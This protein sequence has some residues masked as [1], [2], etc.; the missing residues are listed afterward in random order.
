M[1]AHAS[2]RSR[3]DVVQQ[4]NR[5]LKKRLEILERD[6]RELKLSVHELS[7][8]LSAT[9]ARTGQP[10]QPINFSSHQLVVAHDARNILPDTSNGA[11]CAHRGPDGSEGSTPPLL[12][13]RQFAPKVDLVGHAGAVYAV[14]FS[15]NGRLLASGS[16][17]RSVRCWLIDA[18]SKDEHNETLILQVLRR[19]TTPFGGCR[20]PAASCVHFTQEHTHSVSTLSWAADSCSLLSGSYDRTVRLWDVGAGKCSRAWHVPGLGF[21]QSVSFHP[22]S[23]DVFAVGTTGR[24]LIVYDGRIAGDAPAAQLPNDTMV[25]STLFLPGGEHI[26]TGDK[27][28]AVRAWDLRARAC[29]SCLYAGDAH[30]PI[31]NLAL[32]APLPMSGLTAGAL[33]HGSIGSTAAGSETLLTSARAGEHHLLAVNSFDDTLRVYPSP[34]ATPEPR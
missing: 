12:D 30:K 21:V 20:C 13:A 16:F 4:E 34:V 2:Q 6:N 14:T 28:G 18:K 19:Y 8:Q 27:R 23:P 9:L 15:P 10:A 11:R 26:L 33:R 3:L 31:S 32:S 1:S 5:Q 29:I 22:S 7:F 17:D 25:N 24:S